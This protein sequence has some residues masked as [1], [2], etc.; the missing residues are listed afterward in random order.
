MV[1]TDGSRPYRPAISQY[2]PDARHVLDRFHVVRCHTRRAHL[3]TQS[4]NAATP[5]QTPPTYERDLFRARFALLRRADHL[6]EGSP[7]PP[8]SALFCP[9]P[10]ECRLSC[11][12]RVLRRL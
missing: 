8:G 12:P 5:G 7:S 1:V 2:L 4:S 11:A 6:T 10:T 3:G 9:S